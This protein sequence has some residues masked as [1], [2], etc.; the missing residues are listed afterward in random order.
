M[1]MLVL[2]T[3][4]LIFDALQPERLS[5]EARAAI[6]QAAQEGE[7]RCSA[8]SLWEIAMLVEK[9]RLSPGTDSLSFT[10]LS[11]DSRRVGVL[12]ITPEIACLSASLP[13]H[14]D[15]AD[16]LIAATA[17][18]HGALLVTTDARL[19]RFEAMRSLA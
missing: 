11:L 13:I 16:R 12:P 15:P 19:L 9:G 2:D 10:R 1:K 18:I 4:A 7:I 5:A 6:E 17:M 14:G 8:I 3:C